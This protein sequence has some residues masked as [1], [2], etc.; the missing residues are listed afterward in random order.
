MARHDPLAKLVVDAA[1]ELHRQRPWED[2]DGD[3]LLL[4]RVPTEEEP[5]AVSIMGQAGQEFGLSV[6]RGPGAFA[7]MARHIAGE[8]SEER[9]AEESHFVGYSFEAWDALPEEFRDLLRA[10]G[11][12][13]R[14]RRAVPW[15]LAKGPYEIA[16]VPDRDELRTLAWVVRGVLAALEAGELETPQSGRRQRVLELEIAGDLR[17]PTCQVRLVDPPMDEREPERPVPLALP[18]GLRELPR[19]DED[20]GLTRIATAA[21]IADDPRQAAVALLL[22]GSGAIVGAEVLQGDELAPLAEL[23][24]L[25]FRGEGQQAPK[26]G[27]PGRIRMDDERLHAALAPGLAALG[28]EAVFDADDPWLAA[29]A[30]DL[31]EKLGPLAAACDT[32]RADPDAEPKDLAEWKAADRRAIQLIGETVDNGKFVTPRALK[33]FFGGE[34]EGELLEHSFDPTMADGAFLEWLAAD[35]RATKRSRTLIEKLL[36]KKGL[37]PGMRTMLEAR[38][39]AELSIFGVDACEPG[40]TLEVTDIFSG[41]TVTLHDR[42]LS[43]SAREGLFLPLRLL[44]VDRWI[45]PVLAGPPLGQFEIDGALELLERLGHLGH[46]ID[47]FAGR[48]D[49]HL[50]GQLFA[51]LAEREAHPPQLQN[52]DGDPL[53]PHTATLPAAER[54]A[55]EG[56]VRELALQWIETPIPALDHRTPREACSTAEGR[57]R[58][59]RL[60]RT[61]PPIGTPAGPI[62]APHADLLRELGLE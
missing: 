58:V 41:E 3:E 1:L 60:A 48:Q 35:Y 30:D 27:L 25:T 45:F 9:F 51:W 13:S 14:T 54:E 8:L 33:R 52:T 15:I 19:S 17:R 22:D 24:T 2:L 56:F 32:E 5:V 43:G 59:S 36:E 40:A 11:S 44:R 23:L 37:A 57:A 28:I 34:R 10:A 47:P 49:A 39:D 62:K 55:Y 61:M 26:P 46:A 38:R 21:T 6:F 20:W 7:R 50:L 29:V 42:A 31:G 4:A 18:G 53:P 16:R 12:R